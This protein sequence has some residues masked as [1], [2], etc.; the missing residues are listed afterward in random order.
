MARLILATNNRNKL[1]EIREMLADTDISVIS[2]QEAGIDTEA[3][4]TGE[5]FAENAA[6]KAQT[7]RAL[8]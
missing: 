5:T 8:L 3:E 1:R 2:Q 6:I 4:E 7:I